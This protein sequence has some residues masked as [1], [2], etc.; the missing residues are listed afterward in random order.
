M[1]LDKNNA[2]KA[3]PLRLKGSSNSVY[4]LPS[5]LSAVSVRQGTLSSGSCSAVR[6][7]TVASAAVAARLCEPPPLCSSHCPTLRVASVVDPA[8]GLGRLP[9]LPRNTLVGVGVVGGGE[10]LE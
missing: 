6:W 4:M 10:S 5:P 8:A 1:E 3:G 2:A 9:Q 7:R